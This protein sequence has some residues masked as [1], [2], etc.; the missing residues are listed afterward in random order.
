MGTAHACKRLLGALFDDA[1]VA[2]RLASSD[3]V[4]SNWMVE[5]H[6]RHLGVSV[7][8]CVWMYMYVCIYVCVCG[9]IYSCILVL[10]YL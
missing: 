8:V 3:I 10:T 1:I 4:E 9:H 6:L 2:S 5:H 7:C